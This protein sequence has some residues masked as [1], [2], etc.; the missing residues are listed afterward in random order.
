MNYQRNF[1]SKFPD[2]LIDVGTK[3]NID[4]SVIEIVNQYNTYI[5]SKDIASANAL[6]KANESILSPY[7]FD[8][9]DV[10]RIKEELYNIGLCALSFQNTIISDTEPETKQ[11]VGSVWLKE[12]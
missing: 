4:D 7:K 6:Y 2:E 5:Q 10:N 12:Y 1:G 9:F 8:S 3:K 11:Y